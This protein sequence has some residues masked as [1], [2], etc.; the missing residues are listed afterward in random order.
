MQ[1]RAVAAIA[2]AALLLAFGASVVAAA[3]DGA[4]DDDAAARASID[5]EFTLAGPQ[6]DRLNGLLQSELARATSSNGG[7]PPAAIA[8]SLDDSGVRRPA[9]GDSSVPLHLRLIERKRRELAAAAAWVRAGTG[10]C[11]DSLFG[12]PQLVDPAFRQHMH[13][14]LQ[15]RRAELARYQAGLHKLNKDREASVLQLKLPRF[16]EER[17]SA[18][19][20]A[21]TRQQEAALEPIYRNRR[22]TYE[23]IDDLFKFMDS[24][25]ARF[26]DNR[27]QFDS[28]ADRIAAQALI[29]RFTAAAT[30][31]Q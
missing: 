5:R 7:E 4:V 31:P 26:A 3:G 13:A 23:A 2:C 25:P 8:R 11:G 30:L 21:A 16:A 29:E 18:E 9:L 22:T 17:M 15:C 6:I 10:Q 12:P 14:V 27:I 24:H 28:D 19:A 20:R 1:D